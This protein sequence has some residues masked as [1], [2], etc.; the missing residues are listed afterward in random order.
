MNAGAREWTRYHRVPDLGAE[1]MRAHFVAHTY[2]RHSHD[3]YSFGL[4][5]SGAQAFRCRGGRHV[6][7]AGL[8][9]AFNPEDP[10][11]GHAGDPAGFTYRMVHLDPEVVRDTLAQSGAARRGLPLFAEPVIDDARLAARVARAG[12]TLLAGEGPLAAQEA[13]DALVLAAAGHAGPDPVPARVPA[14]TLAVV[15]DLLH[16]GY[17]GT[18]TA[19]DLAATA[20]ASRFQVYRRFRERYGLSPSAYLR[21]VRLWA[22]R[23]GLAAGQPPAEVAAAVGFA[24]QAHLTRW[25]RR[26]YG[27]TPATYQRASGSAR[28]RAGVVPPA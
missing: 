11:D 15:R 5:E 17:A 23:R 28:F 27:I 3:T 25:F 9:L 14:G 12:A 4:T 20:G 2:H 8:V 7:T 26:T 24:D 19:D 6:S 22:A 21:Q 10:H 18:V 1:A 16:A 13:L